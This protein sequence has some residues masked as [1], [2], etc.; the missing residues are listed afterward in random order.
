MLAK[1]FALCLAVSA[2]SCQHQRIDAVRRQAGE[3]E[4]RVVV[5]A[6]EQVPRPGDRHYVPVLAFTSDISDESVQRALEL[7]AEAR[8]AGAEAILLV[9]DSP[10]GSVTAGRALSKAIEDSPVPVHC[11]IDGQGYSMTFYVL[12]SC[13]SRGATTRSGLMIHEPMSFVSEGYRTRYEQHEGEEQIRVVAQGMIAHVAARLGLDPEVLQERIRGHSWW[14][15]ARE[16]LE[17]RAVDYLVL[18][19]AVVRDGLRANLQV[20][21]P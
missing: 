14:M 19:A 9:L 20:P 15:N 12:Q 1:L 6:G 13:A 11:L 4:P 7:M 10:G 2:C 21:R 3:D 8:D 17:A 16:A 18:R 5:L